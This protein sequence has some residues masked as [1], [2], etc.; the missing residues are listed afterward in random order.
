MSENNRR[1][2]AIFAGFFAGLYPYFYGTYLASSLTALAVAGKV[3]VREHQAGLSGALG[4]RS[5]T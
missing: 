3:A 4:V 5:R 2:V 1:A